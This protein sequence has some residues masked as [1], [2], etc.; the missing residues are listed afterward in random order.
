MQHRHAFESVDHSLRDIMCVIDKR[1]A[2]KP[3]G[4]ITVVFGGDYWHIL[5]VIPKASRAEILL[6]GD[7]KVEN[8][9]PDAD[10]GEMLI[11]ITYQYVVQTMQNPIKSLFEITYPDFLKNISS[12]SYLRSRAILTPTNIV[13]DDINNSIL[14]KI[15]GRLHTYLSQDSIDDAGDKDNDFRSAF[16]VEYLNSL[17]MPCIPKHE[18]NIKVGVVVMLMRNLNEIMG[19]CSAND[20]DILQEE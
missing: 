19:L 13:V 20:C 14:E 16:P 17:N 9:S 1:R 12:H 8:F 5:P 10:T 11:K 6:V 7:G 2:N 4:G 18:L 15:P 3:F